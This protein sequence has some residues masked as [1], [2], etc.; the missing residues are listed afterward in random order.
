[1]KQILKIGTR[2]IKKHKNKRVSYVLFP[3]FTYTN[4]NNES[5]SPEKVA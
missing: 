4:K 1:M 2:K 3:K 5:E